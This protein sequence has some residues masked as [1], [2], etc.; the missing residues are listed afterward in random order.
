MIYHKH[1]IIP[2]HA[3]GTDDPDNL[4]RLSIP[5]HAEAHRLLYEQYGRVQDKVAWLWLAGRTEEKEE[6]LRELLR[7][8]ERC[9]KISAAQIGNKKCVGRK[10][11]SETRAKISNAMTGRKHQPFSL[12]HRTKISTTLTGRTASPETRAKMSATLKIVWARRKTI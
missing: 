2:R 12:E 4:V 1:H 8:P 7:S 6:A 3:G 9:A 10:L 5:E 11:S